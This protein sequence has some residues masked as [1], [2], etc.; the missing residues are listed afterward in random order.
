[1]YL[2][3]TYPNSFLARDGFAREQAIQDIMFANATMHPAYSKLFFI[4]H[5]GLNERDINRAFGVAAT[6]INQ[7]WQ[8]VETR[9]SGQD[10]LGGSGVSAADIMLSVYSR[11]GSGFPV[12]IEIG[13]RAQAMI[14][15]VMAMQ[16]FQT[17]LANEQLQ[18]SE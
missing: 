11:W 1:L 15:R 18:K 2:L 7:L 10:Y 4:S 9:L 17:A 3:D 13:P 14:N 16:S 6:F 12:D 8:V 5:L